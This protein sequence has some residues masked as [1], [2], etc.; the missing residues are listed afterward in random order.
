M[1]IDGFYKYLIKKD[2]SQLFDNII[3]HLFYTG[4][5]GHINNEENEIEYI[6]KIYDVLFLNRK[7]RIAISES[8]FF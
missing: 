7:E 5:N 6:N 4:Q 8:I 3:S 1:K 2:E